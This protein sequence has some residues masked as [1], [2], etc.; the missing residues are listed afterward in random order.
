MQA[1]KILKF[2]IVDGYEL[3]LKDQ[4]LLF[5]QGVITRVEGVVRGERR[6]IRKIFESMIRKS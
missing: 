1:E 3:R 6:E 5:M 4:A 2:C